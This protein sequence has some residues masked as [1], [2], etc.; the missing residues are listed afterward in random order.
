MQNR[1]QTLL[2]CQTPQHRI[3]SEPVT[4]LL[5]TTLSHVY[6]TDLLNKTH[7]NHVIQQKPLYTHLI[8]NKNRCLMKA[9]CYFT[10]TVVCFMCV[11]FVSAQTTNPK[12]E[13]GLRVSGL[14][15]QGDLSPSPV[16]SYK[17]PTFGIG[18]FG[19]RILNKNLSLR[20]NLDFGSLKDADANYSN[21]EW[22]Q[23]RNFSFNTTFTELSGH[24]VYH[25]KDNYKA[26]NFNPYVF[27]G[28]GISF[29]K[30]NR[31]ASAFQNDFTGWQDW[32]EPGLAEDLATTPPKV[33]LNLPVGVGFRHNL[34]NNLIL[35]VEG[36]YRFLFTDYLDGFSK[37]ADRKWKDHYS[38]ASIGLI[39]R[40]GN[41]S[42]N[43]PRY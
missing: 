37:S 38:N 26:H 39:Y 22:K 23:Y 24:A 35:F 42:I 17:S 25:L 13:V 5:Y 34:S 41:N 33:L 29:I 6:L 7:E 8:T 30:V 28:V 18:F 2:K 16:G 36:S 43:C 12:Y 4:Y 10:T 9:L 40:F 3:S 11:V 1:C 14:I 15:Y 21:P 31:D 27:G 19:T 20:A 32:V